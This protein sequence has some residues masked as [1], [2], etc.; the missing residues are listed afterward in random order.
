MSGRRHRCR[1]IAVITTGGTIGSSLRPSLLTEG[2]MMRSSLR[3]VSGNASLAERKLLSVVQGW[4]KSSNWH[5][6]FFHP[7]N[8]LSEDIV[9]KDWGTINAAIEKCVQSGIKRVLVTH[10]TDTLPYSLSAAAA[11]FEN[12]GVK[13]CFTGSFHSPN[14][15]DS[16]VE[17]SAVSGLSAVARDDLPDGVYASFRGNT[18]NTMALLHR[19][20]RLKPMV[21][22]STQF[23]SLYDDV[24][25]SFDFD[26]GW[27]LNGGE[28]QKFPS[29]PID[30]GNKVDLD[31]LS[32]CAKRIAFI[33]VYPGLDLDRFVPTEKNPLDGLVVG[34]YHSGTGPSGLEEGAI[35]NFMKRTKNKIPIFSSMFPENISAPYESI[36]TLRSQGV[37]V[38]RSLM[39][40]QIY[41]FLVYGLACGMP[42]ASLQEI[43]A[44]WNLDL[45]LPLVASAN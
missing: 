6:K 39:P 13:I 3:R 20:S 45:N 4:G 35:I 40:H 36:E 10:G 5:L 2:G 24:A 42:I 38:F 8:K 28:Y 43:L 1:R 12:R 31:R 32:E 33:Q 7:L 26:N 34:L 11:V 22:D 27:N 37:K 14:D 23:E 41:V 25:G 18:E 21:L 15:I 17:L 9:P 16:D 44:R 19:A 29:L 30:F